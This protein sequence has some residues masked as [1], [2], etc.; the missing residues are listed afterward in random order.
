MP[1]ARA[2]KQ[3]IWVG[4]LSLSS[5]GRRLSW[6]KISA[7]GIRYGPYTFGSLNSPRARSPILGEQQ[8][9]FGNETNSASEDATE[10]S[11]ALAM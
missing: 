4:R 9:E 1:A 8:V 11:T 10:I 2:T 7:A 3:K 6:A 5:R